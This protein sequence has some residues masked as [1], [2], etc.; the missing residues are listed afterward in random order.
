MVQKQSH[1]NP[2][3]NSGPTDKPK[4]I[5]SKTLSKLGHKNQNIPNETAGIANFQFSHYKSI[6][7]I[8]CHS[9]QLS[10]P[11]RTKSNLI[12]IIPI[13]KQCYFNNYS[14][15]SNKYSRV[16]IL[17]PVHMTRFAYTQILRMRKMRFALG[18]RQVQI[19]PTFAY[20][21]ILHTSVNAYTW[22]DCIRMQNLHTYANLVM[23]TWL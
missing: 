6:G 23:C 10:Y 14:A 7:A 21:Q 11:I 20:V 13:L 4:P 9:N 2:V 8:S 17:L 19:F 1:S 16:Q 18:L 3:C 12:R 15:L 5:Y 22:P